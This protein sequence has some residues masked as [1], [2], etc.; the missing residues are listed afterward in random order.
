MAEL[1]FRT[2]IESLV[3]RNWIRLPQHPDEVWGARDR[4]ALYGTIN[5]QKY[6]GKVEFPEG[7]PAMV[8]F[9]GVLRDMNLRVG[10]VVD[11]VLM[12]EGPQV[13][14]LPEAVRAQLTPELERIFHS[15]T[16]FDRKNI[17]RGIESA[18]TEATLHKR[19]TELL[20]LLRAR[21]GQ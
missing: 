6:R 18:K 11:V 3:N 19:F 13:S 12:T 1:V 7:H 8:M 2:T 16:T 20:E 15:L 17:M 21:T 10:D 14:D 9:P 5:G 4:H